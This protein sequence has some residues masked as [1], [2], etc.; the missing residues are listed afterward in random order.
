MKV[1]AA[2]GLSMSVN[3]LERYVIPEIWVVRRGR[4]VLIA[5]AELETIVGVERES[6]TVSICLTSASGT[7]LGQAGREAERRPASRR[8]RDL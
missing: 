5:R 8:A 6:G 4:L 7:L 3:S 2:E 1:E